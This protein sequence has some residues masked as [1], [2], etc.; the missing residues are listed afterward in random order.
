MTD[1]VQSA[2]L[3]NPRIETQY[4]ERSTSHDLSS[5]FITIL[6]KTPYVKLGLSS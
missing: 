5:N 4:L 6:K 3:N 1:A 2:S